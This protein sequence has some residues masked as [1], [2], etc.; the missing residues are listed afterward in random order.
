M[1]TYLDELLEVKAPHITLPAEC[2]IIL[3]DNSVIGDIEVE[4]I[5]YG[6]W[7]REK[8]Y[9]FW[10]L[11]KDIISPTLYGSYLIIPQNGMIPFKYVKRGVTTSDILRGENEVIYKP[12]PPEEIFPILTKTGL[13]VI[14]EELCSEER[15]EMEE[16]RKTLIGPSLLDLFK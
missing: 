1:A 12:C 3:E 8:E 6:D 13:L 9:S 7:S 4:D 11:A 15:D 2:I 5:S 16:I 10:F 14:E